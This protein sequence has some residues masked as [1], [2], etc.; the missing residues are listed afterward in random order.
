MDLIDLNEKRAEAAFRE[1]LARKKNPPWRVDEIVKRLQ[2][3]GLVQT[4][5]W[6]NTQE[7]AALM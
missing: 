2:V 7:V 1:L 6:L 4:S 5:L 3:S